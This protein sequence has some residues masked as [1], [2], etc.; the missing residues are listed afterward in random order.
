MPDSTINDYTPA[1]AQALCYNG[2]WI[3]HVDKTWFLDV[4]LSENNK[5]ADE[6]TN[7]AITKMLIGNSSSAAENTIKFS[8]IEILLLIYGFELLQDIMC[9][10]IEQFNLSKLLDKNTTSGFATLWRE[11]SLLDQI[12]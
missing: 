2:D 6:N 1:R 10:K 9:T 8:G 7:S 4:C 11:E 12:L 5:G 3:H